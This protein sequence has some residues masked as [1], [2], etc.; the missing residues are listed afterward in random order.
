MYVDVDESRRTKV[1]RRPVVALTQGHLTDHALT[2]GMCSA[3]HAAHERRL[4]CVEKERA[5][6]HAQASPSAMASARP[7]ATPGGSLSLTREEGRAET[8][9]LCL[10]RSGSG[11]FLGELLGEFAGELCGDNSV[12]V[13]RARASAIRARA[14]GSAMAR[15]WAS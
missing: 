1:R 9:V 7:S 15:L 10:L 2:M 8:W 4:S 12:R 6:S 5:L 3:H 14:P 13:Q 11:E